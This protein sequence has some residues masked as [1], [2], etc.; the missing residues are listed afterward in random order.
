MTK[1]SLDKTNDPD[2][3]EVKRRAAKFR[4]KDHCKSNHYTDNHHFSETYF[5]VDLDKWICTKCVKVVQEP[6]GTR[7][8]VRLTS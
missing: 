2:D 8:I 5:D 7:Q 4:E 1:L 3:S 6:N